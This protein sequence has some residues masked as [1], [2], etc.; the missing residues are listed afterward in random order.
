[1]TLFQAVADKTSCN[2]TTGMA[3]TTCAAIIEKRLTKTLG[4]EEVMEYGM[5]SG[6]IPSL[7][8]SKKGIT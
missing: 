1:M 6:A 4:V 5:K 8:E 3:C 7:A 2:G